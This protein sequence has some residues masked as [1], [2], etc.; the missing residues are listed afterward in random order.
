MQRENQQTNF[1]DTG[2]DSIK[3]RRGKSPQQIGPFV[4]HPSNQLEATT[5][6]A[7]FCASLLLQIDSSN[8]VQ[9]CWPRPDVEYG[10]RVCRA[11]ETYLLLHP[12]PKLSFEWA[13]SLLQSVS[14]SDELLAGSLR[15]LHDQLCAGCLR[16]RP[17]NL[18]KLRN[19]TGQ[20]RALA[21]GYSTLTGSRQNQIPADGI[22]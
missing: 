8:R 20:G 18:P 9:A 14:K 19:I 5:L 11:F 16:T 10:H 7:L 1:R 17:Q 12:R 13:W 2:D 21:H 15:G 3:R 22:Q 6:V 4:K